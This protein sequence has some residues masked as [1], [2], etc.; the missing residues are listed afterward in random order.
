MP[1]PAAQGSG[2]WR[3]VVLAADRFGNLITNLRP[4]ADLPNN[5]DA[6]RVSVASGHA[7]PLVRTY[8]AASSKEQPIA[9]IGSSGRLE[10]A[11]PDGSAATWWRETFG[12]QARG[13]VVLLTG[14]RGFGASGL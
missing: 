11:L 4:P 14:L 8:G 3:G 13:G 1:D 7:V 9:L 2:G 6:W 5:L 12:S 10:I